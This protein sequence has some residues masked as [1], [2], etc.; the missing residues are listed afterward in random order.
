MRA[1][2]DFTTL[3]RATAAL[4][5][6]AARLRVA[7]DGPDRL[8][9]ENEVRRLGLEH[10]V[11]LLGTRSDVDELLADSDALVLSSD[12]EGFPMSVIE[13]MASGVAVVASA[14]GGIPEAVVDGETGLLVPRRDIAALAGALGSLA[15]DRRR[16]AAL[17]DAGRRRAE[18]RFDIATFQRAHVE[19]YRAA[20]RARR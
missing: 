7:G 6:G 5:P 19:L 17:G 15:D 20:L 18:E 10:V 12:S 2:K 4:P 1:P 8:A 14:V 9:L 13:A 3:V 16:V 11:Q